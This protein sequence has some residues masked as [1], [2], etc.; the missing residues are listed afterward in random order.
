MQPEMISTRQDLGEVRDHLV[1][2]VQDADLLRLVAVDVVGE[3]GAGLVPI[4]APCAEFVLDHPL[5]EVLVGHR[6]RVVDAEV[7]HQRQLVRPGGGHDAIDHGVREGAVGVDPVGQLRVGQPRERHDRLA[8]DRAVALQVVAAL[9]GERAGAR[10]APLLQRRDHRAEGGAGRLGVG[11]VV[12]D[13]G[14]VGV[15]ALGGRVDVIAAFGD[16]QRD[17]ADGRIGHLR[18][19]RAV[20]LFDRRHS[21]SSSR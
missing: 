9:A 5:A 4:R 8:Q 10:V 3:R 17:D 6:G 14:V 1:A 16:G 19:Q 11:G 2:G 21:R 13:V 7:A 20:A 15:E 18:D 12:D